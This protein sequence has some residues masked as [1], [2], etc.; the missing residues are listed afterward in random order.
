MSKARNLRRQ[1]EKAAEKHLNVLGELLGQFYTF[2]EKKLEPNFWLK[3]ST[4]SIIAVKK[5]C[6][7]AHLYC[8]IKKL[9]RHG[10]NG[11]RPRLRPR[12]RP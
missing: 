12:S 11:I 10:N 6:L 2:L 1:R 7:K 9:R 5:N 3:R 8:L 4:G